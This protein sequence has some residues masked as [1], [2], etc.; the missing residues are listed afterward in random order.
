MVP[1]K[2]SR[3][4]K[5]TRG[6]GRYRGVEVSIWRDTG[7]EVWL[8]VRVGLGLEAK[9]LYV[10]PGGG[11]VGWCPGE[12]EPHHHPDRRSCNSGSGSGMCLLW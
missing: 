4:W 7:V 9:P 2:V 10:Q 1:D 11:D 8:E 12:Y 5:P 3:A 6:R